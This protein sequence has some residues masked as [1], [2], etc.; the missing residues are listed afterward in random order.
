MPKQATINMI[1]FLHQNAHGLNVN[2]T[3][4]DRSIHN[5]TAFLLIKFEKEHV[6]FCSMH[7]VCQ[8]SQFQVII[9]SQ[10]ISEVY[11]QYY[12]LIFVQIQLLSTYWQ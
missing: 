7:N 4:S 5:L 11:N 10:A 2:V 12:V 1:T 8:T 6:S 3:V 9:K